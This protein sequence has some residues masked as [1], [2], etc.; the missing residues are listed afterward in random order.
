M[1]MDMPPDP[2][3]SFK[4]LGLM[5]GQSFGMKP[6]SDGTSHAL[7]ILRTLCKT[8]FSNQLSIAI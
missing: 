3:T 6:F 8:T 7:T 4:W 2:V 1:L 5:H